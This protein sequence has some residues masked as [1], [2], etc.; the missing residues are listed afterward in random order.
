MKTYVIAPDHQSA[1]LYAQAFGIPTA[2]T[3]TILISGDPRS[4]GYRTLMGVRAGEFYVVNSDNGA[5]SRE[6]IIRLRMLEQMHPEDVTVEWI[7]FGDGPHVPPPDHD[8]D[9]VPEREWSPWDP[10]LRRSRRGRGR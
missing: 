9:T 6:I 3:R 7:G 5:I 2:T 8:D 4:H 10:W 1:Y